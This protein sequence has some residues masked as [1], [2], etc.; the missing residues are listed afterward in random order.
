MLKRIGICLGLGLLLCL[1][2]CGEKD[3]PNTKIRDLEFTVQG[4]NN[5]PEELQTIIQDK[6]TQEF[7]VTYQN[8]NDLYICMGYGEQITG[9][10]SISVNELYLA[11]NAVYFDTTLIGPEPGTVSEDKKAPSYPYVVV[12]TEYIDKVIVFQ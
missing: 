7:K 5:L 6:K 1:A 2:G 9:G 4:E 8:G 11:E 3:P 10:Y 12:K